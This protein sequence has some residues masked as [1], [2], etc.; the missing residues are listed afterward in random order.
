MATKI[1][2]LVVYNVGWDEAYL[3]TQW[4]ID[5]SSRL[6]T[7]DIGRKLGRAVPLLGGGS[8]LGPHLT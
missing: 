2:G 1:M 3:R 8:W 5:P 6:A 4:H 7:T